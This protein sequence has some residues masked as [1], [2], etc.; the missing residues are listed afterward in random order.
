MIA[1]PSRSV[2]PGPPRLRPA[3]S[4]RVAATILLV[5]FMVA[6]GCASAPADERPMS[7]DAVV[8]LESADIRGLGLDALEWVF[9]VSVL[10]RGSVPLTLAGADCT[11]STG[12]HP[13]ASATALASGP[14]A[15]GETR[16]VSLVVGVS[17]PD[18]LR[19][20]PELVAGRSVL[21]VADL[22]VFV[23][24]SPGARTRVAT[25]HQDS[26][27]IPAV[28]SIRLDQIR[29][30]ELS[31]D[32]ARGILALHLTNPNEFG[33]NLDG[34]SF[35]LTVGGI[36]M[37]TG[38]ASEFIE[39]DAMGSTA[40]QVRVAFSPSMLGPRVYDV[41][42]GGSGVCAL[43]GTMTA[44]TPFGILGMPFSE[45]GRVAFLR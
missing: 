5:L 2:R 10:N 23:S 15:P 4:A 1:R 33:I 29:W 30:A 32:S 45:K 18:L 41:L 20:T 21:C 8:S 28:P 44:L 17:F 37:A 13:I 25:Q 9:G 42:S 40:V 14:I 16:L 6:G 34:F 36:R 12:G 3:A 11:L 27:P 43:D 39:M 38:S 19:T 35:V 22:G 24:R 31:P 7:P 26:F